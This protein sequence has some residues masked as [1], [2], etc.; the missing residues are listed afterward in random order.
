MDRVLSQKRPPIELRAY[1]KEENNV[2]TET[3]SYTYLP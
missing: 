1:L 3:W 2:L